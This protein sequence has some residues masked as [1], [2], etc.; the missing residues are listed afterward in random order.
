M[1]TAK[2]FMGYGVTQGGRNWAPCQLPTRELLEGILPPFEAVVR[3]AGIGAVMNAYQEIDGTPCGASRWLLTHLLRDELGFEGVVLADYTTVLMLL[4]FHRITADKA[5]AAARAL[6]AGLD[7]ELPTLDCYGEPLKEAIRAGRYDESLIDTAVTRVLRQKLRLGLFDRPFVQPEKAPAVFDLPE[8]R[9][10]ARTLAQKS[11]VLLKNE[12]GIL[13]LDPNVGT[14]AV[15]GPNADSML[16]LQGDYSYPVHVQGVFGA[17]RDEGHMDVKDEVTP[18]IAPTAG[19]DRVNLFDHFVPSV[20]VLAG[21]RSA[22]GK[23]T[24]VLSVLGCTV[25]GDSEDGFDQAV[26]VA[27][28]ADAAVVVV[29]GRSGLIKGATTGESRDA[30]DLSLTGK[31]AG[32]VKAVVATGTPTVVVVLSGRV[33]ALANIADSA[34]ALLEAWCPGEEGGNGIADV[35][36][37]R[38]SPAG[39]LP[40]SFPMTSGQIPLYYNHKPSGAVSVWHGDY[41][42][43][44]VRPLFPFGHGLTYTTFKYSDLL[45]SS[46][47]PRLTDT[48]SVSAK[49]SN[50][51]PRASDEVAQLY[52]SDRVASMTRPVKELKGFVR[53][54]LTPGQAAIVRFDLDLKQLGFYDEDMRY[55]VEPGE[56]TVQ[57]GTSSEDIRLEETIT[58]VGEMCA[59]AR[60]EVEP[61][62]VV[63]E[64]LPA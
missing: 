30:S 16:A 56:L 50:T 48:L 42:D 26:N 15:I 46:A 40:V 64:R 32:L 25:T 31:Q 59:V 45:L 1:A 19:R 12:A 60:R 44:S 14:L 10:L 5:E 24:K 6:R 49:I 35:L 22:V 61:T 21:I 3:E 37:G 53:I 39:R 43:A 18:A 8:H 13:P 41:T 47:A 55:V 20:S 9:E 34:G 57:L 11:V 52:V 4:L 23:H 7:T 2:H 54:S 62:R 51:G 58:T 33:H 29:G 28:Q 63:V 36:F 17:M 38:V 27:K